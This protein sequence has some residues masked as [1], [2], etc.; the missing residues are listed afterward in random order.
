MNTLLQQ[1]VPATAYEV[2]PGSTAESF[3]QDFLGSH[4]MLLQRFC[5]KE[6][7]EPYVLLTLVEDVLVDWQLSGATHA[8]RQQALY[9]LINHIRIKARYGQR[10]NQEIGR[11]HV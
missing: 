9:H 3:A 8:D 1:S 2:Y 11:A 6:R 5:E 4:P 10:N 7:I